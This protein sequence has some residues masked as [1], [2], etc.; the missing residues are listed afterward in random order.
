MLADEIYEKP[1]VLSGI[2]IYNN[3]NS[4]ISDYMQE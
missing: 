4:V 3:N 1:T 2:N